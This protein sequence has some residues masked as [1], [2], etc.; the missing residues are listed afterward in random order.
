MSTLERFEKKYMPDPNSGCWLWIGSISPQGYGHFFHGGQ[1][2]GAHRFSYEH[3]H[4]L[5]PAGLQ[6]D[7][8]C[9]VRSCVNPSHLEP[10]TNR[11]NT[12]RG[13][14]TNRAKTA[15]PQ[16]HEYTPENTYTYMRPG[17]EGRY[18]RMCTA[19][20]RRKSYARIAVQQ[21]VYA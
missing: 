2:V 12:L 7:H 3:E 8:L 1:M 18:C 14:N 9:R 17:G 16:G 13:V 4:G 15:C 19:A 20:H 11:E 21:E 10:V 6:I 5:I